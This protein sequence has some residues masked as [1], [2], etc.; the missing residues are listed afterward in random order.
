MRNSAIINFIVFLFNKI[1]KIYDN[2]FLEKIIASICGFFKKMSKGSFVCGLFKNK[3]LCGSFWRESVVFK[4]ITSPIRLVLAIGKRFGGALSK[5][6]DNSLILENISNVFNIPLREYGFIA[7]MFTIGTVIASVVFGNIT[8]TR[9]II[10]CVMFV[11]SAVMLLIPANLINLYKSS[12]VLGFIG[13]LFNSY[14]IKKENN[15]EIYNIKGLKFLCVLFFVAG[16]FA[17]ALSPVVLCIAIIGAI[18]IVLILR[19]TII[20][21]F[22][23]V[24]F[25]PLLPTMACVGITAL[26][27]VS[28]VLKLICDKDS[29]YTITPMSFLIVMFVAL[30]GFSAFA[31]FNKGKS[32][33]I[34]ALYFIFAFAYFIIVNTIKTKN[35]WYNMVTIFALSGLIVGMYGIYQNFFTEATALSGWVDKE[36]FDEIKMRVYST[37]D[38]P[39]VLGQYLVLSIPVVFALCVSAKKAAPRLIFFAIAAVMGVC[40]IFTWSRA[41]WVGIVLAIGFFVVMKDRRWS[42]LCIVALLILPFVIPESIFSRITSI[43]DMKDSSTAYRVSVWIASFRI[44]KDYWLGGIGLGSGAFERIY[45]NYALNGAGFALHSHN[46][47]IQLV[48][49]MGILGLV[50]FVAI[51]FMSY[52]QIVSIRD[53][54]SVNKNVALAIGGAL[55]GYLFQGMA[56]NLWYNYR[57]VFIFWIYLAILQSGVMVSQKEEYFTLR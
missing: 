48:V 32:L 57:M 42:T 45:Q 22:A 44:A 46:F 43:G 34:F 30:A 19:Y 24:F 37:F 13:S 6:I 35:E 12:A 27:A 56:E 51:I 36:M 4:I 1:V 11:L 31:S 23:M 39:N 16:L 18:S 26:T 49:E 20:G 41:A 21:V 9:M 17:G 38:N 50:L 47:Y 33:Q 3:F 25:A 40:L 2:S 5:K 8:H 28:F 54:N 52:K 15:G 14:S 7:I 10:F 55:I 29:E 53:K